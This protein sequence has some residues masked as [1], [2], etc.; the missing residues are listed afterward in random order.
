[1]GLV[2]RAE[3]AGRRKQKVCP[4]CGKPG[5]PGDPQ[6]VHYICSLLGFFKIILFLILAVFCIW[7]I[8]WATTNWLL[9]VQWPIIG[10]PLLVA[11]VLAVSVGFVNLLIAA[12]N[13]SPTW[14]L[15]CVILF[16]LIGPVFMAYRWPHTKTIVQLFAGGLLAIWI[17]M[18]LAM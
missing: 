12:F 5:N 6:A 11:G 7:G 17:G 8:F 13:E 1:M 2:E 15:G 18:C 14:L 16:P 10:I 3:R 4:F 9:V